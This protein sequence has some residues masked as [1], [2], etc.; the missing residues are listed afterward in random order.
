LENAAVAVLQRV[1]SIRFPRNKIRELAEVS[2][3]SVR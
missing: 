3:R 2:G 1:Y